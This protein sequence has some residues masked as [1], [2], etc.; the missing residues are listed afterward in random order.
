MK[1]L[2]F[3]ILLCSVSVASWAQEESAVVNQTTSKGYSSLAEAWA[4]ANSDDVLQVNQDQTVTARLNANGRQITIKGKSKSVELVRGDKYTGLLLL[5]NKSSDNTATG[6]IVLEDI[7]VNGS[8]KSVG[9][10]FEA[11]S[12]GTLTLKNVEIKDVVSTNTQGI[13]SVKNGGKLSVNGV[14]TISCTVPE[15]RG[16]IFNGTGDVRLQ[17]DNSVSFYMEKTYPLIVT[18]E[19][20][21]QEPLQL[22]VDAT[23]DLTKAGKLVENCTDVTK[24][25]LNWEGYTL[26]RSGQ[27]LNIVEQDATGI[28]G[29]DA[30]DSQPICVYDLTGRRITTSLGQ[31]KH[32][33]YV[34]N[35]R[36]IVFK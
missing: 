7:T 15:G 11:S 14:K 12:S 1:N 31:L 9:T 19:L 29:I 5:T 36:K 33:I 16:E 13:V 28:A 4:E 24:F 23:R 20:L 25:H 8:S 2:F 35:G 3:S 34:V 26:S 21:N 18:G 27:N 22:Y 17:G 30:S 32:G 10:S 6:G